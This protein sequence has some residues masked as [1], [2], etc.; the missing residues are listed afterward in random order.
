MLG[1]ARR[2]A[3]GLGLPLEYR[4]GDAQRLDWP[5][6]AFDGCRAERTFMHLE[7]PAQALAEMIRVTRSGGRIVV[8]DFDWDTLLVDHP[9]RALSNKS[10]LMTNG[11]R[12][13]RIGRRLPALF[14]EARLADISVAAH[15]IL[16]L[17]DFFRQLFGPTLQRT[18]EAGALAAAEIASWWE[19]LDSAARAGR[20][21]TALTG[22][23]VAGAKP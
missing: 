23:I 17:P 14:A 4:L 13:G 7:A 18:L 8:F 19:P 16:M 10:E 9:E 20:F 22:F 15:T 3:E 6:D 5:A 1:E 2:R 11:L 12:S 21:F